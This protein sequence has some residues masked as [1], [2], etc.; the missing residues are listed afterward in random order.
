MHSYL[1]L[2]P[3][4]AECRRG[5]SPADAYC[6]LL[7]ARTRS[8]CLPKTLQITHPVWNSLNNLFQGMPKQQRCQNLITDQP[9]RSERPHIKVGSS[10]IKIWLSCCS[11]HLLVYLILRTPSQ[12]FS[13]LAAFSCF[14]YSDISWPSKLSILF[15]VRLA[16]AFWLGASNLSKNSAACCG[17]NS[18]RF[19]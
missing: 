2:G 19:S 15:S 7:L 17:A 9:H 5:S 4:L 8:S 3:S 13:Y 12:T 14:S 18:L 1:G 6:W 16:V 10:Q 11:A